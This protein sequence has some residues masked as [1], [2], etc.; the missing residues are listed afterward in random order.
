MTRLRPTPHVG[1]V[2]LSGLTLLENLELA[3]CDS[4]FG[5]AIGG[6]GQP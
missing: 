5:T 1:H 3:C 6:I 4:P 2:D